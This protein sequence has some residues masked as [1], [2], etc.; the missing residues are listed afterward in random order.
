[1]ARMTLATLGSSED[2]MGFAAKGEAGT[3][4][5]EALKSE[6]SK[7][8]TTT[9]TTTKQTT[10]GYGGAKQVINDNSRRASFLSLLTHSCGSE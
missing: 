3:F 2:M 9:T 4:R 7:T 8:N 5:L 6:P 10:K 1:M